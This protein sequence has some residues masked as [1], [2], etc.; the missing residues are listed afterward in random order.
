MVQE[1]QQIPDLNSDRLAMEPPHMI[2]EAIFLGEGE[3]K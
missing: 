1:L 2:H 3:R